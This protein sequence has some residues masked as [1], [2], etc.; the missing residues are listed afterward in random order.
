M[1]GSLAE[2]L[3]GKLAVT[4]PVTMSLLEIAIVCYTVT[5]RIYKNIFFTFYCI[6]LMDSFLGSDPFSFKQF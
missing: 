3:T 6:V 5:V 1:V 2:N 4:T